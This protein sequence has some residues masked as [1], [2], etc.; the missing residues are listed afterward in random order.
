MSRNQASCAFLVILFEFQ[1]S[2]RCLQ[3]LQSTELGVF[4][5]LLVHLKLLCYL[6]DVPNGLYVHVELKLGCQ[7]L[8]PR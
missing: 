1:L 2:E 3:N 4:P 7:N 8:I 5:R 6:L